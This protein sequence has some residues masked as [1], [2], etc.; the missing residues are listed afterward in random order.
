MNL[1]SLSV[2]PESLPCSLLQNANKFALRPAYSYFDIVIDRMRFRKLRTSSRFLPAFTIF[3]PYGRDKSERRG[4]RSPALRCDRR[5]CGRCGYDGCGT[6]ARNGHRVSA[7]GKM[8]KS[9]RKVRITGKGRCNVTNAR[10]PEEF[11]G[12][13]RTNA[14]FFDR[15]RR[16]Q[17]QGY[18]Q[19]LRAAGRE[20]R[21]RTRRAGVSSKRQGVDIANA[22]LEYC[23]D[24]GV[25]IVY[26]TR[27][28]EIMTLNGRVFGVRYR[29]KRDSSAR[30]S[31]RAL[32]SPRAAFPI[33]LRVRPAT[34]TS[35]RPIRGMRSNR[36]GRRYA[37]G[38]VLSLDQKYERTV[39]PECP[40]DALHRR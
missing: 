2:Y 17:Q 28:T 9:G 14:E 19:I 20:A 4:C 13:V 10:P 11:A 8:E 5:R 16:V 32:S 30:R 31:V 33:P 25:K 34:A 7:A 18:D 38:V 35:L 27:V 36:C 40:C 23:V 15:F 3:V 26:D 6:A 1:S 12:Q 37:A 22:L 29:N 21:C 39:A 24:N